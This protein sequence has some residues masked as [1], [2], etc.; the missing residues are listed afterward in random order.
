MKFPIRLPFQPGSRCAIKALMPI[1]EYSCKKCGSVIEK[2][3]KFSDPPL[4]K[5]EDCGGKLTKLISRSSFH[6][7]GSGWY[8]TDYA[9]KDSKVDGEGERAKE[10]SSK[11]DSDS[12]DTKKKTDGKSDASASSTS[13][14]SSKKTTKTGSSDGAKK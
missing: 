8:V 4:Q 7:K 14:T 13:E 5:H 10:G 12:K 6:L 3:Q 2:I 9:R 11:S 1:Y